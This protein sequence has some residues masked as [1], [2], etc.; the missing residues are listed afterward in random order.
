MGY[1]TSYNLHS[2][3]GSDTKLAPYKQVQGHSTQEQG[4]ST[5]KQTIHEEQWGGTNKIIDRITLR[6][7][8]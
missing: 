6:G 1:H 8:Q 4:V 3:Q 5:N 2:N 7:R